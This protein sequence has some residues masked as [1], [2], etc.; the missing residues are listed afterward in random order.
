MFS[1]Q[2]WRNLQCWS[3]L[4]WLFRYRCCDGE[5]CHRRDFPLCWCKVSVG[6]RKKKSV[7]FSSSCTIR[8]S[9]FGQIN[10]V[11]EYKHR[12]TSDP[13]GVCLSNSPL[14]QPGPDLSCGE[15]KNRKKRKRQSGSWPALTSCLQFICFYNKW[16]QLPE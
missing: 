11:C 1:E 7:P 14:L 5:V 16:N 6:K 4:I 9:P 15:K 10:T 8:F 13:V 3:R 12:F 2:T